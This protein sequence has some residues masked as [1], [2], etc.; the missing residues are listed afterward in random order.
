MAQPDKQ[1]AAKRPP[2]E[3]RGPV[4]VVDDDEEFRMKFTRMLEGM[5][6]SVIQQDSGSHCVRFL[7]NQPWNWYP[8]IVFTDIVMDGMGGYQLM[9]RIQELYPRRSI[10]IIVVS[11]LD[12]G[13]DVGEAEVAG[14]AAYITKPVD[15][16][17]VYETVDKVL[18]AD[19]KG[20]LVFTSDYGRRSLRARMKG[21]SE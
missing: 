7:Q 3:V 6:L 18:A 20:M 12:A 21:K 15:E 10:P 2:L 17:R 11:K 16:Q 19:R 9:R 1:N 8:S 4:V 5:G 13:V 14:A